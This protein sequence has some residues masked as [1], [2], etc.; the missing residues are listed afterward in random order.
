MAER[1]D[2][3]RFSAI[4]ER[5]G[6]LSNTSTGGAPTAALLRCNIH[7]IQ[8]VASA[9]ARTAIPLARAISAAAALS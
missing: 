2:T 6:V 8:P 7:T 4:G 3:A 9:L 1:V 5:R